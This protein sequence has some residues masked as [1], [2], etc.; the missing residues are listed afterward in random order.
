[1]ATIDHRTESPVSRKVSRRRW[2]FIGVTVCT[3]LVC[4]VIAGML[5]VFS[6][7]ASPY[8]ALDAYTAAVSAGDRGALDSVLGDSEHR[9]ALIDRHSDK[10]MTPTSVSMEM[11]ESAVWWSVEIR[12]EL[13]GQ[14]PYS[15][16]LLVHPRND[17]PDQLI[18]Y[19]IEPAP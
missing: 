18:D 9:Q 16:R 7:H 2:L 3:L 19:V 5:G 17:S 11:M 13:W 12:Y 15:E 1:M 10:P 6:R 4:V 8:A 14:Q